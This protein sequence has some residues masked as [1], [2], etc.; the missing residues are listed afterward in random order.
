MG[1]GPAI[2]TRPPGGVSTRRPTPPLVQILLRCTAPPH[3]S[4]VTGLGQ[5]PLP[6]GSTPVAHH[7]VGLPRELSVDSQTPPL[8]QTA[9]L[10]QHAHFFLPSPCYCF[11]SYPSSASISPLHV[12]AETRTRIDLS[13]YHIPDG[14]TRRPQMPDLVWDMRDGT[15]ERRFPHPHFLA[16]P[17]LSRIWDPGIVNRS[18]LVQLTVLDR[19]CATR[20]VSRFVLNI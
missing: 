4:G 10:F 14:G 5:T 2:H 13:T 1:Q 11:T 19:S 17:P 7:L 6:C 3:P 12:N 20:L 9:L 16:P 15:G 8:P 18:C